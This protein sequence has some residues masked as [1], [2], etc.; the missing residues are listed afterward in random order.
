MRGAHAQALGR[1]V[2]A[3]AEVAA[4]V[5]VELADLQDKLNRLRI[6]LATHKLSD[7]KLSTKHL[8]LL[9]RQERAMSDYAGV[10]E[11]R[12]ECLESQN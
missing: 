10:L 11:E 8:A 9:V 12:I 6:F 4:K 1:L 2:T 3:P 7:A 5:R